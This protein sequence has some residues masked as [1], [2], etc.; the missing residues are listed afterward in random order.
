MKKE[1]IHANCLHAFFIHFVRKFEYETEAWNQ[2]KT[3][4]LLL[5]HHCI[6]SSTESIVI[7]LQCTVYYDVRCL[8]CIF[9]SD[10]EKVKIKLNWVLYK[11]MGKKRE[12]TLILP[13]QQIVGLFFLFLF[14]FLFVR[15]CLFISFKG[16]V[17]TKNG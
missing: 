3:K 6:Q 2:K 13:F 15:I 8:Y 17:G 5:C 4:L 16:V 14:F 7:L 10:E 11:H 1:M 9:N 12:S